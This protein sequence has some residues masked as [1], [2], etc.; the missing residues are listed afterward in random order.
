M[1]S[2]YVQKSLSPSDGMEAVS[3][4]LFLC[5]SNNLL[6]LLVPT[7]LNKN[8]LIRSRG[9][10]SSASCNSRKSPGPLACLSLH[11]QNPPGIQDLLTNKFY[12]CSW[13][14]PP[15]D[16]NKMA[17]HFIGAM[18]HPSKPAFPAPPSK[19]RQSAAPVSL[20]DLYWTL[21]STDWQY[22]SSRPF[23]WV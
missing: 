22:V 13:N 5:F 11:R 9:C 1:N 18:E 2:W 21:L 17:V 23:Q 19:S 14:H 7:T 6:K 8:Q 4:G 10:I 20:Q 16:P 3:P 12:K 15:F